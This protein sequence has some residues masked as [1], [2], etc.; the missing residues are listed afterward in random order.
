MIDPKAEAGDNLNFAGESQ[1]AVIKD[2]LIFAD[3]GQSVG[4][5]DVKQSFHQAAV[6]EPT[7]I[8]AGALLLLPFGA[9]M[10]RILRKTTRTA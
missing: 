7:T 9:G 10:L 6:P 8:I 3:A 5:S 2:I 4:L 1:L